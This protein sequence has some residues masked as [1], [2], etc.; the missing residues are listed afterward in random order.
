MRRWKASIAL[1]A[2]AGTVGVL[3]IYG[4][5]ASKATAQPKM[6]DP[7]E[8][9]VCLDLENT[10]REAYWA[11]ALSEHLGGRNEYS[12][13]HGRVDIL[14]DS[15]A[16]EVDWLHKFHLGI[17]QALYYS[18]E[19]GKPPG[20]A[21]IIRPERM[22]LSR[23]DASKLTKSEELTARHGVRLFILYDLS[24]CPAPSQA[25]VALR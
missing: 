20:L 9:S 3:A 17:G 21:V 5:A 13:K 12:V 2:I 14:T 18:M 1:V 24:T 23:L 4:D 19:T 22:P 16:I 10:R 8:R 15:H 11:Q 6:L 25:H 7:V